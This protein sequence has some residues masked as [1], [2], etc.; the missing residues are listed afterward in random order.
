MGFAI[1]YISSIDKG[2]EISGKDNLW[3]LFL[4]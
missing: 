2:A 1:V 4:D 3:D